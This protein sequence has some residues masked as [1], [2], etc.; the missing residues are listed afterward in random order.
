[1]RA[2]LQSGA[3]DGRGV[4]WHAQRELEQLVVRTRQHLPRYAHEAPIGTSPTELLV[5]K[6]REL[7]LGRID[8]L[9]RH[10]PRLCH[11]EPSTSA[12]RTVTRIA[13]TLSLEWCLT[14]P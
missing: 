6:M 7:V 4:L 8:V 13:T 10:A 9:A 1:M 12:S 2:L 11:G 3:Q 14:S 5:V